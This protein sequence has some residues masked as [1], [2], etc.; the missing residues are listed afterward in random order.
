MARVLA[1][2]NISKAIVLAGD[3]PAENAQDKL[4][5]GHMR[6][7]SYFK[8]GLSKFHDFEFDVYSDRK[9][10]RLDCTELKR[11]KLS[12]SSQ[13]KKLT[14][15]RQFIEAQH[16]G[17]DENL[18]VWNYSGS[19]P[20]GKP[21]D[22]KLNPTTPVLRQEF[23]V[24]APQFNLDP[25][26]I[27]T[28][29]PPPGHQDEGRILPHIVF[30]D[31]HVP[32]L[33]EAGVSYSFLSDPIDPSTTPG[34][35]GRNLVP[36]MALIAFD[37]SE[38]QV[39]ETDA[40]AIGLSVPSKPADG[41]QSYVPTKL[42]ADGAFQMKIG[43]YLSKITTH[44]IYYE[45]GYEGDGE[46]DFEEL[47]GEADMT[48]VIFPQKS[49]IKQILG[50]KTTSDIPNPVPVGEDRIFEGQKVPS[51]SLQQCLTKES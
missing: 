26:L 14:R 34:P 35:T 27:N 3:E 20:D 29:Y 2:K 17:L 36:W 30:N 40:T 45:A 23:S 41:I 49:L 5:D 7:Y 43:E 21:I 28:F 39:S 25:K 42:P 11:S 9:E 22:L 50:S 38:L 47:K 46:Q 12:S 10:Q 31:P 19:L 48:N 13:N 44:R 15:N 6:L 33:R 8:P 18:S 4:P 51:K 37:P 16:D 1:K 24:Q 32:W